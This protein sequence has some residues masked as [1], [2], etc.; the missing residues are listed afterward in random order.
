LS[1]RGGLFFRCRW[2]WAAFAVAPRKAFGS[3]YVSRSKPRAWK[4]FSW[5]LLGRQIG[6][7]CPSAVRSKVP[8]AQGRRHDPRAVTAGLPAIQGKPR[9]APNLSVPRGTTSPPQRGPT[10]ERAHHLHIERQRPSSAIPSA[11]PKSKPRPS[12]SAGPFSRQQ[13]KKTSQDW[14]RLCCWS[15]RSRKRATGITASTGA[16]ES[17]AVKPPETPL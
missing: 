6:P 11:Q 10:D 4:L 17:P 14:G 15:D 5:L 8:P 1:N 9:P 2:A 7:V 13:Q 12:R 3:R 16:R